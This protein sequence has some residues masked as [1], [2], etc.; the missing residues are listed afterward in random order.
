MKRN[1]LGYGV[2]T[3]V[4]EQKFDRTSK[5]MGFMNDFLT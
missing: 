1:A 2:Y 5:S 3:N 4:C